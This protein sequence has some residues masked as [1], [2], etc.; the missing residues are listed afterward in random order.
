M[1]CLNAGLRPWAAIDEPFVPA[2]FNPGWKKTTFKG[3]VSER[4]SE[5]S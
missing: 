3:R 1:R 4:L 2:P 5:V